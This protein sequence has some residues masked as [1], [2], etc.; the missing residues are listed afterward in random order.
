MSLRSA[1]QTRHRTLFDITFPSPPPAPS[2]LFPHL[3]RRCIRAGRAFASRTQTP[4]ERGRGA[5]ITDAHPCCTYRYPISRLLLLLMAVRC[6][7]RGQMAAV[8]TQIGSA[9][10]PSPAAPLPTSHRRTP[11]G[12]VRRGVA[13]SAVKWRD[14]SRSCRSGLVGCAG[15]VRW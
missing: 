15:N 9:L 8:D 14:G 1:V 3:P 6:D 7:W 4:S 13:W 12:L 2:E 10:P 11:P 5:R